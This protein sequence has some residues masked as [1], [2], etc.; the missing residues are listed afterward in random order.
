MSLKSKKKVVS[1]LILFLNKHGQNAHVNQ[2][3]ECL[4][5]NE[6]RL[7]FVKGKKKNPETTTEGSHLSRNTKVT[8]VFYYVSWHVKATSTCL[9]HM[10]MHVYGHIR[11]YRHRENMKN[12]YNLKEFYHPISNS[13][14]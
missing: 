9:L 4:F 14:K 1:I 6:F 11:S 8:K 3:S 10:M 5:G 13:R 2:V 7:L 12:N